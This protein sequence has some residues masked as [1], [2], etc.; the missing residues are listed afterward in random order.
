MDS[1]KLHYFNRVFRELT[2]VMKCH[3]YLEYIKLKFENIDIRKH[4]KLVKRCLY[5]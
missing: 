3:Y 2:E 1:K 5:K 4:I